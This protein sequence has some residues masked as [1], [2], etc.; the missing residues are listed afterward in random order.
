MTATVAQV[1][2]VVSDLEASREF[3]EL[4]GFA[5]RPVTES[6]TGEVTSWLAPQ[7]PVR[8]A[9][10]TAGSAVLWDPGTPGVAPGAAVI[11][12]DVGLPQ[13]LDDLVARL[14][15]ASVDVASEPRDLPWGDRFAIVRDPDG[16]RWGLTAAPG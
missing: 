12:L 4:L 16:Y 9:L 3:Y 14:R 5:F 15:E 11:E 10:H 7:G 8:L 2:L 1:N 13:E 6:G